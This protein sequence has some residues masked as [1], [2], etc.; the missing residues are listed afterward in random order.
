MRFIRDIRYLV[1]TLIL[2]QP[3]V[4][5]DQTATNRPATRPVQPEQILRTGDTVALCLRPED[6]WQNFC[7]GLA[8]AYSEVA[9]RTGKACIPSGTTRRELVATFIG[10]DVVVSTGFIDD[11]PALET[12]VEMFIRHYPCK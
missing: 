2:V 5:Q 7:D 9:M 10:P 4:A 12:A 3:A 6:H 8:Q 11:L 1:L